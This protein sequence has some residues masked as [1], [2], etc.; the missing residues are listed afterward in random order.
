[1]AGL[2]TGFGGPPVSAPAPGTPGSE[3]ARGAAGH[4]S[5]PD[6]FPPGAANQFRDFPRSQGDILVRVG[7]REF[8]PDTPP[9]RTIRDEERTS[10]WQERRAVDVHSIS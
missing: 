4:E 8:D 7:I 2:Q 5:P 6:S 1:N 10:Q 9:L 3:P